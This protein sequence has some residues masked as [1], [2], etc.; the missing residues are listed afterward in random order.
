VRR[1]SALVVSEESI[2]Q[3]AAR[4]RQTP[5]GPSVKLMARPF[6]GRPSIE[7]WNALV[8]DAREMRSRG[9]LDLLVIDPL[10]A[11][12]PGRC[13]SDA[14]TLLEMLQPLHALAVEGAAVLL[15][16]HPR[17]KPSEPGHSARGSGA[18]LGFV[19]IVLELSRYCHL[20]SDACR[21]QII[22]LS[23]KAETPDRLAY[24]LDPAT[25]QFKPLA[26]PRTQ[27]FE[28]NWALL[29]GILEKRKQAVTHKELLKDWPGDQARPSEVT[30]YE[31]LNRA[32]EEKR[33]RREG[34]GTKTDPWRYRLENEDD[35]YYDRGEF[36]PLRDFDFGR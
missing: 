2:A 32:F 11:F 20:K 27:Q 14:A 10:A 25:G 13:E 30:L 23:R 16:H 29:R 4:L 15:L 12:L 28:D 7:E 36:P 3:W 8:D 1:G 18:L 31:W 35:A 19:D 6:R 9:E 17:K 22:A 34:S 24:E 21:R 5:I 26:N 33:L